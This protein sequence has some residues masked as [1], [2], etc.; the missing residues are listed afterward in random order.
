MLGPT[1]GFLYGSYVLQMYVT[2]SAHPTIKSDDP[3]WIGAWWH[4]KI[5]TVRLHNPTANGPQTAAP[6]SRLVVIYAMLP[7]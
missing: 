7:T 2:P 3:R 4:G 5:H 6:V 1:L